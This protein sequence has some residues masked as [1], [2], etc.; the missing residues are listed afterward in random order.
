MSW[1]K[2]NILSFVIFLLFSFSAFGQQT[3]NYNIADK[4]F[5]KFPLDLRVSIQV[6]LT[7][8]G[9]W[10]AIPNENFS[11]RLFRAIIHFQRDNGFVQTGYLA[12]A[13]IKTLINTAEPYFKVWDFK[14]EY[15]PS[16]N[17]YIVIPEGILNTKLITNNGGVQFS[18]DS[19][20]S[21]IKFEYLQD[22]PLDEV[23]QITQ[24]VLNS[25][26][27]KIHYKALKNN[28]FVLSATSRSGIDMYYRYHQDGNGILGFAFHWDNSKFDIK[29]DRV[30]TIVSSSFSS[31]MLGTPFPAFL[32]LNTK[33][34]N[35]SSTTTIAPKENLPIY[36]PTPL[37][38]RVS[39][40]SG[41]GFFVNDEG[42]LITNAHVVDGCELIAVIPDKTTSIRGEIVGIDRNNDLAI[43]KT[44]FKPRNSAT[45]RSQVRLG[46]NI[47]VFGYPLSDT[48]SSSGNFTLGNITAL[49]GARDNISHYQ[50]SA[51]IQPGNSGGALVD[52]YGNAVGVIVSYL[53][54]AQNVNF[55]IKA[56]IAK[57]FLESYSVKYTEGN[58]EIKLEPEDIA[59]KSKSISA[60]LLCSK[61]SN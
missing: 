16:R 51:P 58:T 44:T 27:A 48:L 11:K 30:A 29:G 59:E 47:A 7:G 6:L 39:F 41:T 32:K 25:E 23:F 60:F 57:A 40:S 37:P 19:I 31:S 38:Q 14:Q 53:R 1:F 50:I 34:N 10:N 24:D 26:G 20:N 61:T 33:P 42:Y 8:S 36:V 2:K 49:S 46:E 56:S 12:P 52:H 4:E 35:D 22:L 15:H 18:N 21:Y 43:L 9:Y 28:F 54:N 3:A 55:A 13:E 5:K 17:R 45:F